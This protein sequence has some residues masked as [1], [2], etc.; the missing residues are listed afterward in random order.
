[1]YAMLLVLVL[2]T[3]TNSSLESNALFF[4]SLFHPINLCDDELCFMFFVIHSRM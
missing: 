4:V 2:D 3:S 1:M